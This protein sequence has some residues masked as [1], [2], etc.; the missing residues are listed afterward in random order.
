MGWL[1]GVSGPTAV[2]GV[3]TL[4][5]IL[6]AAM[7]CVVAYVGRSNAA[8]VASS[9][10]DPYRAPG[11]PAAKVVRPS[12]GL[13]FAGL[14]LLLVVELPYS[15]ASS[16][17]FLPA[18]LMRNSGITS[19]QMDLFMSLN[20]V[21]VVI[22]SVLAFAL[23]LVATLQRWS[24]PPLLLYGAGVLVF[25]VGLLP[26]ALAGYSIGPVLLG[27]AL[28]AVGEAVVAPVALAYAA[29][30]S[31]GRS[32]AL[33]IAGWI[34]FANVGG[35]MASIMNAERGLRPVLIVLAVFLVVAGALALAFART[36]HRTLFDAPA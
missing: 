25:A 18:E 36:V 7:A 30:A 19:A 2:F 23:F 32:R 3:A 6:C 12:T 5:M 33:V 9:A 35:Q 29:L 16:L 14:S 13:A 8:S 17:T 11:P 31:S 27:T 28:T 34:L 24:T 15:M 26:L 21:V 1:R 10:A 22:A 20:P 4:G